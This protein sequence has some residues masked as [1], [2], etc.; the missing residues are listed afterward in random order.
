[1]SHK[2]ETRNE[3]FSRNVQLNFL[4]KA[5]GVFPLEDSKN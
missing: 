4:E 1:M 3:Y 5:E 2:D